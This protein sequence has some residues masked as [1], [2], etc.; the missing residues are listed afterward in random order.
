VCIFI[1]KLCLDLQKL[2]HPTDLIRHEKNVENFTYILDDTIQISDDDKTR[3]RGLINFGFIYNITTCIEYITQTVDEQI[4]MILSRTSIEN[5]DTK[6]HDLP[7][8][9]FIYVIDNT[10]D[11]SSDLKKIRG[12]YTS[13]TNVC[14]QLEKDIILFTYDLNTSL[15]I[16][17]DDFA[18]IQ[19][20]KDILLESDETTDLKKEMLDFCRQA[21]AD[22]EIQ[23]RFI[24]EFEQHFQSGEAVKWYIRQ[25]TFLFKMLTRAFRIPNPDILFKLRFFIQHLHYQLES[26]LST[27]SM[28]VYRTQYISNDYLDRISKNQDGFLAFNQFLLTNKTRTKKKQQ[29]A[30]LSSVNNDFTFV[31]FQIELD[32][33][34]PMM[35]IGTPSDEILITAATAFRIS[36]IE[37]IDNEIPIIKLTSNTDIS[38]AAKSLHEA[39]HGP[40]PLLRMAKLMKQMKYIQYTEYFCLILMDNPITTNNETATLAIGGLFHMLC[41]FYY[42]QKQYDRALEQLQKSLTVYLR[43]LPSDDMKLTPTYNNIGS[44]YHKQGLDEQALEFHK[45]A[46][47]I[48]LKSSNPDLDS[49]A[50]YAGNIASVLVK[51]GKYEEAIPYLQRDLQ[52]QQRLDSNGNEIHLAT[53]Y[54]NLAGAQYKINK[55]NKALENYNKCLEIELKLHPANHPTVA[56]TY[57]NMATVLESSGQLEKAINTIKKS[58]ERLLLTRDENDEEVQMY[59][60]YEKHLQEKLLTRCFF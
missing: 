53:K 47:D 58:I 37:Q 22:N 8:L 9:R 17:A 43:V 41:C 1:E 29:M 20:L 33:T 42:E 31:L 39:T 13:I 46:Y 44:I 30:E 27:T 25:D 15:S 12:I 51:Q 6:I 57:H 3:L 19:V 59:K 60:D 4:I 18:Y 48:Q 16:S 36:N 49:V 56:V 26:N 5:L 24:D 55:Y 52:I 34:I 45:K 35:E 28:T 2:S 21:Y 10:K 11:W 14:D 50:A 38:K 32:I 54:H 23:L 7:Q 40:F